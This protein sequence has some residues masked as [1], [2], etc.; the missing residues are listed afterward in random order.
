MAVGG[1]TNAVLHLLALAREAK[2]DLRLERIDRLSAETPVLTNIM[3]MGPKDLI[4]FHHAG[5]MPAVQK[6][7][8]PLLDSAARTVSGKRLGEIAGG[9]VIPEGS[10]IRSLTDPYHA[11]GGIA[12]VKGSL[13]PE[14]AVC[15]PAAVAPEMRRH[16]G[17]ALVFDSE[18]ACLEAIRAD[19]IRAGQVV[20]IRW[21]G[22]K[23]GPGMPEMYK[24]M[25]F[26]EGK[27]LATNVALVTDGRF[28][29]GNRGGFVGHVCPEAACGGPIALV[30]DGDLIEI[31]MDRGRL[32]LA[33]GPDELHRRRSQGAGRNPAAPPTGWLALYAALVDSASRGAVLGGGLRQ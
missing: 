27:G 29:G 15:K 9:A 6:A 21:V 19:R 31:D 26:L 28:S 16:K 7:M 3:P 17:P 13:A 11:R 5:G 20:V 14:G 24:P 25:K 1:S 33:V 30:Q 2:V 12:V 32:D 10:F 22:P 4:E 18:E 8:L 23:G